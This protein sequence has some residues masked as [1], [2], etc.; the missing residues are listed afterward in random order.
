MPATFDAGVS[1][2]TEGGTSVSATLT[3][4]SGSNRLL[5]VSAVCINSGDL[6]AAGTCTFRG[7]SLGSPVF[8]Q[9]GNS[10]HCY[11]WR[12][13]APASGSGTVVITPSGGAFVDVH[14]SAWSDVD[15][16]TPIPAGGTAVFVNDFAT[17][18]RSTAITVP[19]GGVA[20]DMLSL[21]NG[22][23]TLTKD[24]TQ[25]Q[26]G[27]TQSNG[28]GVSAASYKADATAM[29]WTYTPTSNAFVTHVVVAL[30]P[31]A[32][33]TTAPVLSS[34]TS[35]S[36]TA[37]AA[38]V[39]ATTDE[40]NGTSHVVATLT[41]TA[42][43][44]AQI[45]AGQDTA[46]ASVPAGRQRSL[47]ISA[48]GAFTFGAFASLTGSTQHWYHVVHTDAAGNESNIVTGTFTTAAPGVAPTI[49][50]QPA[51]T[52]RK[53][54]QTATFTVAA[55]GDPTLTY[56][57]R[58]GGTNISGAT[59]ASYTTPTLAIGDNGGVYSVVVSNGS[60]SATSSNATLTVTACALDMSDVNLGD[61][62]G[63]T[64]A[65]AY[66]AATSVRAEV[67]AYA[68]T[69][70][71]PIVTKTAENTSATGVIANIA[72]NALQFGTTYRFTITEQAS[73]FRTAHGTK[74]AG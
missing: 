61:Y 58:L 64:T 55:T 39:G 25:T 21:R 12:L 47:A 69:W 11:V 31:A 48:T 16:T 23:G 1:A 41:S 54:G 66:L 9:T 42:P 17:S 74:V 46:G 14:V 52:S 4:G 20:V 72:D 35:T 24:A 27:T 53:V 13:V 60:G 57:W 51:N 5:L 65:L 44:K 73:P 30:A 67:F 6:L 68:G 8:T 34:P 3:V 71:A 33:D 7:S 32:G 28:I 36:V 43:T 59:S 45:K 29:A 19:A 37:S 38:T 10:R 56:Q 22:G 15:Q 18:P 40:A 26:I 2:K 63:S 50:T 70:G 62:V 49:T